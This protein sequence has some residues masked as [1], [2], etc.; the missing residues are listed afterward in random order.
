MVGVP[1][2]WVFGKWILWG[3]PFMSWGGNGV[4]RV[5]RDR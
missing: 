4:C 5:E 2:S 3:F 1:D